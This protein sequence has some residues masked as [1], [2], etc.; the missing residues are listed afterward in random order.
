MP[1]FTMEGDNPWASHSFTLTGSRTDQWRDT[2]LPENSAYKKRIE[3]IGFVF[4]KVDLETDGWLITAR[5]SV[6]CHC[7]KTE[8]FTIA[9]SLQ[10]LEYSHWLG[11]FDIYRKLYEADSFSPSHLEEDGFPPEVIERARQIWNKPLEI[12]EQTQPVNGFDF[13]VPGSDALRRRFT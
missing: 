4:Q 2:L 12:P 1:K 11:G 7:G 8:Y 9:I 10:S 5:G 6:L 3:E 13:G